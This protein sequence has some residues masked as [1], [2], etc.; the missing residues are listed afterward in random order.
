MNIAADGGSVTINAADTLT[1]FNTTINLGGDISLSDGSDVIAANGSVQIT[2]SSSVSIYGGALDTDGAQIT[3]NNIAISGST[4]TANNGDVDI[5]DNGY[6]SLSDPGAFDTSLAN[7]IDITGGSTITANT[8][9]VTASTDGNVNVEDSS[10]NATGSGTTA[11]NVNITGGGIVN[12]SSSGTVVDTSIT[13]GGD[14]TIN[15]GAGLTVSGASISANTGSGTIQ[16]NNTSGQTTIQNGSSLNAFYIGVNSADG[17]LLDGTSP[18]SVTGHS[19]NLASG[20]LAATDL[21]KVQNANLSGLQ[22][23]NIQGN[24]VWIVNTDLGSGIVNLGSKTGNVN[25]DTGYHVWDI[26]LDND[27]YDHAA[28]T[29]SGQ[30]TSGTIGSTPGLYA[31]AN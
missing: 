14:V 7:N 15:A 2:T 13:A 12:I 24:T 16:L 8:G 17:I 27:V 28:I 18:G 30:V 20:N 29:S 11:G 22:T 5:K 6:L 26:N 1:M 31:H 3:G 25:V 23:I 4:V 19:L 9:N 10:I 21:V